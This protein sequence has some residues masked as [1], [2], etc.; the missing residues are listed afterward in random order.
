MRQFSRPTIGANESG[1]QEW[2][3]GLRK[4]MAKVQDIKKEANVY[5]EHPSKF[6][7]SLGQIGNTRK[8][9]MKFAKMT[10]DF[11]RAPDS[12]AISPF[13]QASS[14]LRHKPFAF[15]PD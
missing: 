10:Q 2:S 3:S 11:R 7:H 15:Y 6:S 8:G 5:L 9:E 12:Y 13:E 1:E 14:K 4:L